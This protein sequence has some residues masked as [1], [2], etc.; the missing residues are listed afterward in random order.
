MSVVQ[1]PGSH[2]RSFA[3]QGVLATAFCKPDC[4]ALRAVLQLN[5]QPRHKV[6]AAT[7]RNVRCWFMWL[8]P[9]RQ[10]VAANLVLVRACFLACLRDSAPGSVPGG[11]PVLTV[12]EAMIRGDIESGLP[13]IDAGEASPPAG[14]MSDDRK[15]VLVTPLSRFACLL[16]LGLLFVVF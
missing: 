16:I 11:R 1:T 9:S 15:L 8:R 4:D 12:A 10:R 6:F 7:E 13:A 3:R 14:S 2:R 5:R